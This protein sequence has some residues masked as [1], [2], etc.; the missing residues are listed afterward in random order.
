MGRMRPGNANYPDQ[1]LYLTVSF[2]RSTLHNPLTCHYQERNESRSDLAC[3]LRNFVDQGLHPQSCYSDGTSNCKGHGSL[4]SR[5]QN[6]KSEPENLLHEHG[7]LDADSN[8]TRLPQLIGRTA[9]GNGAAF[10]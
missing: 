6:R 8:P 2:I 4:H 3:T 9:P 10:D 5:N 1:S 7:S